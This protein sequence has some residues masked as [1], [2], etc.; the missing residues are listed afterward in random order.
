M[1][2][3]V[4]LTVD[5]ADSAGVMP[6]LRR[7]KTLQKPEL[8]KWFPAPVLVLDHYKNGKGVGHFIVSLSRVFHELFPILP[9]FILAVPLKMN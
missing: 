5:L 1:Y 2:N 8:K 7:E 4:S 6:C 9:T 3:P